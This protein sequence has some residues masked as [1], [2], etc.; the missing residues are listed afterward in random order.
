MDIYAIGAIPLTR[1]ARKPGYEIFAVTIADIKKA[2]TLKKYTNPRTKLPKEYYDYLNV[3]L[4][5]KSNV[6]PEYRP[7][8]YKI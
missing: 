7:Y 5:K 2:L 3:F 8:D 4:R 6:L 1:L